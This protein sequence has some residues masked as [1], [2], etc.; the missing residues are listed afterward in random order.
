MT[1][2]AREPNS[3]LE[4][5]FFFFFSKWQTPDQCA[6]S[7]RVQLCNLWFEKD[8]PACSQPSYVSLYCAGISTVCFFIYHFFVIFGP[9]QQA[10]HLS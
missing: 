5:F 6:T 4:R 3:A 1:A 9:V 10:G 8:F 7:I 2:V